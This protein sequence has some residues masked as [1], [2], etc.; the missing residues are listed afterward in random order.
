MSGEAG[1]GR[2]HLQEQGGGED[3]LLPLSL[4]R[5]TVTPP[6]RPP[7]PPPPLT[8]TATV[9]WT[10]SDAVDVLA[11]AEMR[12]SPRT[13]GLMGRWTEAP[14]RLSTVTWLTMGA[15]K[16]WSPGKTNSKASL[17]ATITIAWQQKGRENP[18]G[19]HETQVCRRGH[20]VNEHQR[21]W[22]R[23]RGPDGPDLNLVGEVVEEDDLQQQLLPTDDRRGD[24]EGQ[25]E[26]SGHRQLQEEPGGPGVRR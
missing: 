5:D 12:T 15:A 24:V 26:L 7:P 11:S 1:L 10:D 22:R 21:V 8:F 13:R 23:H 18:P 2:G 6:P 3:L 4:D 20:Q 9:P 14:P 17:A 16:P 25:E 19:S